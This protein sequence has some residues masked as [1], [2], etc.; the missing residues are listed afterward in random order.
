M[1]RLFLTGLIVFALAACGGSKL[2]SIGSMEHYEKCAANTTSFI[3]MIE[4]GKRSRTEYC[5]KDNTCS[6]EGNMNVAYGDSLVMSVKNHE[7]T[8]AEAWRKWIAYRN[9]REDT[10][11]SINAAQEAASAQGAAAAAA[12]KPRYTQCYGGRGSAN[13][14]SY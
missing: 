8:E 12:N 5:T 10:R 11:Q 3:N 14:F 4:C 6:G 1:R 2:A 9:S 13:C 7:I